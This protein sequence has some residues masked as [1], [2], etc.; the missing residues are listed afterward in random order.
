MFDREAGVV[1]E[2]PPASGEPF[3]GIVQL[4]WLLDEARDK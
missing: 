2:N 3:G 4:I 1:V